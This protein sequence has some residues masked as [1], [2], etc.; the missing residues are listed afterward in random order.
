MTTN[1]NL[2]VA[3]RNNLR[4]TREARGLSQEG[5]A[6]HLDQYGY[7]WPQTTIQRIEAGQRRVDIA[8]AHTLARALDITVAALMTGETPGGDSVKSD[9]VR[10]AIELLD[11][12]EAE[13]HRAQRRHERARHHLADLDPTAL[14]D[15]RLRDL[16]LKA[17]N[18]TAN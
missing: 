9:Q 12:A 14:P 15:S 10:R 8:E 16:A 5:L 4:K 18:D 7:S 13:L 11:D 3:F 6:R 17:L 1:A 2:N